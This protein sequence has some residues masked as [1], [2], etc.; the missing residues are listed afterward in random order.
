M[1]NT[2]LFFAAALISLFSALLGG[3]LSYQL[4]RYR[5]HGY[6]KVQGIEIVDSN[7]HLRSRLGTEKDGGAYLR[8]ISPE[9]EPVL[10]I[11]IQ[12]TSTEAQSVSAPILQ[13]NNK[14][15]HQAITMTTTQGGNGIIAFDSEKRQNTL[16]LGYYGLIGET[17][18][19]GFQY[20]WGLAVKREHGET[21]V[22]I[23]DQ[24]GFPA[25]Y[26]SPQTTHK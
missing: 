19:T 7:G 18:E 6:L 10:S 24:P 21:G 12:G 23:V 14:R 13:M 16:L 8:F 22:G 20:A 3:A 26:V 9:R 11:G 15:D 25:I 2:T 1:K 4:F 17:N 5:T